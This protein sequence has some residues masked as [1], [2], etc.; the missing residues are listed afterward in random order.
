MRVPSLP[1]ARRARRESSGDGSA[2]ATQA[3]RPRAGH[4]SER[5]GGVGLGRLILGLLLVLSSLLLA[6]AAWPVAA[7]MAGSYTLQVYQAARQPQHMV[8][9]YQLQGIGAAS[10]HG[11]LASSVMDT[12]GA[13]RVHRSSCQ[14]TCRPALTSAS[15]LRPSSFTTAARW[16]RWTCC[17]LMTGCR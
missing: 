14:V 17:S 12:H 9:D 13:G 10:L 6:Y 16:P 15:L 7:A 11:P 4:R 8:L 1:E 3:R 5:P 2:A